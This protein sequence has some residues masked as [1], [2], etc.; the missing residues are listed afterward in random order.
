MASDRY[1]DNLELLIR[2]LRWGSLPE[3]FVTAKSEFI[4]IDMR[5]YLPD[6]FTGDI[7]LH[8]TS[9]SAPGGMSVANNRY[10]RGTLTEVLSNIHADL[11]FQATQGGATIV[12]GTWEMATLAYG[13]W[14]PNITNLSSGASV[15]QIKGRYWQIGDGVHFQVKMRLQNSGIWTLANFRMSLPVTTTSPSD[16]VGGGQGY[17]GSEQK[18]ILNNETLDANLL[19]SSGFGV[20]E[21]N[22]RA[23][24]WDGT[25]LWM[26]GTTRD[27][28]IRL[29]RTTGVGTE[30]GTAGVGVGETNPIALAWDGTDLWTVG[31]TRR[32]LIRLNRTTGVGTEL[33]TADFGVG[34]TVPAALAWDGTD[35][36]MVGQTRRRL[37]RL[38]RTTGVGT[39]L[40]T[41]G[42]GVSET[43]PFA[44]AFDGTDLWMV[45]TTRDRLI[46]LNRTTGVGTELGTAGVGVSETNPIALAWDGTDLWMVGTT[47]DRLIRL[48]RT[49]GVGTELGTAG[50]GVGE[51]VPLALAFDGTDLWTVGTTR[52]QLIGL[53]VELVQSVDFEGEDYTTAIA[54]CILS[55]NLIELQVEKL[56]RND[57]DAFVNISGSYEV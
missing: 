53:I 46:R 38:N 1:S 3:G 15:N 10:W 30:L 50:F 57:G 43:T 13:D 52:E 20:G 23:L 27:R 24:A 2:D 34:E 22:P 14:T 32:R 42:F 5:Q 33:G 44:L 6:W 35:L 8:S 40:G 26:V 36:W 16:V 51:T 4:D 21:T 45:G 48:N 49:T 9:D 18:S 12:S 39:E 54:R 25:D 55:S 56:Q 28:L 11:V 41:S 47:R 29:N 19:G 7:S 37:T 17:G 31:G